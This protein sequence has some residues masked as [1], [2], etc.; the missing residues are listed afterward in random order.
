MK[1][2]KHQPLRA[3]VVDAPAAPTFQVEING[4]KRKLQY[5]FRAF[6]ALGLNPFRPADLA[7]FGQELDIETALLWIRAGMLWEY[8]PNG[9]RFGEEP[10]E[11]EWLIDYIDLPKFLAAFEDAVEAAGMKVK[12]E[13]ASDEENPQTA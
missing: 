11:A 7:K 9:P 6:R 13:T 4:E 10:P 1:Q 8:A 2:S 3:R 5:G 12:G